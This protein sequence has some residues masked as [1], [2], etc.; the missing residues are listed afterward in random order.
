MTQGDGG[1]RGN[2]PRVPVPLIGPFGAERQLSM[3]TYDYKCTGCGHVFELSHGMS[4]DPAPR[5]PECGGPCEKLIT[6]GRGFIFKGNG[7]YATDYRAD[8]V[9]ASCGRTTRCCG[10]TEPCD[11]PPCSR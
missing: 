11:T 7:F 4:E 9:K 2:R 3:P 6:G 1:R 5:C 8:P 10:R